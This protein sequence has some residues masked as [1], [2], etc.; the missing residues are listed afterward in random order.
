MLAL[1]LREGQSIIIDG[2]IEVKVVKWSRSSVR[3]AVQAPREVRVDRDETWRKMHQGQLTPLEI[4]EKERNERF[5]SQGEIPP[6]RRT[7]AE[8]EVAIT[9][10]AAGVFHR[11]EGPA[12]IRVGDHVQPDTI[13]GHIVG[14][15]G[16]A[17]VTA[18]A[19]GI[20]SR[21]LINSGQTVAAGDQ[22]LLV[23]T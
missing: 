5:A 16:S 21:V 12:A 23:K 8:G 6:A 14:T 1:A 22:L 4:A 10:P 19:A 18:G 13:V 11:P 2:H 3:L 17:P 15:A 20:L 7:P 9:A